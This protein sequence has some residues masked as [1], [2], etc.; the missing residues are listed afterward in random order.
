[1][2]EEGEYSEPFEGVGASAESL[3]DY[4]QE[5]DES[6]ASSDLFHS[7]LETWQAEA[8]SLEVKSEIDAS[9]PPKKKRHLRSILTLET[10]KKILEEIDGGRSRTLICKEYSLPPSTLSEILKRKDEILFAVSTSVFTPQRKRMRTSKYNDLE[11]EVWAWYKDM[12]RHKNVTITG[13]EICAQ[14]KIIAAN[15]KLEG[16]NPNNGWLCRFKQRRGIQATYRP[17]S[18]TAKKDVKQTSPK[19]IVVTPQST[20]TWTS[21]I[22]PEI[23]KRY[24]PKDIFT[25]GETSLFFRCTP[26]K[27]AV[28]LGENCSCGR[29]AKDRLTVMVAT[30][31]LGT[32]KLPALAIGKHSKPRCFKSLKTIP[33]EYM[34]NIKSW[35][36]PPF[37][38]H[39]VKKFDR[40]MVSEGRSIVLF[41]RPSEAHPR[42]PDLQAVSLIFLPP[43]IHFQPASQGILQTLK[44][45]YRR[46]IIQRRLHM[47]EVNGPREECNINLVDALHWLRA[48]WKDVSPQIIYKSFENAEFVL[49]SY[50]SL[51][52]QG[53]SSASGAF[54]LECDEMIGSDGQI[55]M[56]AEYRHMFDR[57]AKR[58]VLDPFITAESYASLDDQVVTCGPMTEQEL[59]TAAAK[60][61]AGEEEND[62]TDEEEEEEE[63][64]REPPPPTALEAKQ[65]LSK[66]AKF[67]ATE[68]GTEK[69]FDKI[70]QLYHNVSQASIVAPESNIIDLFSKKAKKRGPKKKKH[71]ASNGPIFVPI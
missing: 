49:P 69:Y 55:V 22:L 57:L 20:G 23:M 8:S 7:N 53:S 12:T 2:W 17:K 3:G 40:A 30:N 18:V 33:T 26:D 39:W 65:C 41:V 70:A 51:V 25:M 44:Q 16:F 66:L 67:F 62:E 64:A 35:M 48:A 58:I 63:E 11:T 24:S 5:Y 15:M 34:A 32:E 50:D 14:A 43:D 9:E 21:K 38:T 54:Q 61:Q 52:P 29:F 56:D 46:S 4:E 13:P 1:M 47:A 6:A 27:M 59:E 71:P 31:M 19:K 60:I 45:N 28:F 36:I 37:F 42:V 10:K 68:K